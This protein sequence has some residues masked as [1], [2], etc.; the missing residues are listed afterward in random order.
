MN[1]TKRRSFVAAL[2][3]LVCAFV[4]V[5]SL[6]MMS[7]C[8]NESADTAQSAG[9]AWYYGT[10][11]PSD[12]LGENGDHYLNT[13]TL[14]SYVKESNV[15]RSAAPG[16]AGKW[17]YG[18]EEPGEFG[19][20]GDFYLKTDT[21][22]LY[23]KGAEGWEHVCTLKGNDGRDGVI[24]FSGQGHPDTSLDLAGKVKKQ[25]DFYIDTDTW[26]VYQLGTE[27]KWVEL[28]SIKGQTQRGSVWFTGKT[29]P[30]KAELEDVQEG[31]YYL[32]TFAAF[33][34]TAGYIIYR[35]DGAN[36]TEIANMSTKTTVETATEFH[37]FDLEDLKALR[38]SVN[39]DAVDFTGKT[40][41][42][43]ADINFPEVMAMA[44]E[45]G[46]EPIG[47]ADH[48]FK[49]TFDGRG[50][51][52]RNFSVTATAEMTAVGL[53]GVVEDATIENVTLVNATV[54]AEASAEVHA[55]ILVGEAKGQTTIEGVTVE[56]STVVLHESHITLKNGGVVG[57]VDGEGTLTMKDTESDAVLA[58]NSDLGYT[59]NEKWDAE[60]KLSEVVYEG[61]GDPDNPDSFTG[62]ITDTILYLGVNAAADENHT[63]YDSATY[64]GVNFVFKNIK[65]MGNTHIATAAGKLTVKDCYIDVQ[66]VT[67]TDPEWG[68][69]RLNGGKIEFT[70]NTVFGGGTG[71]VII[72]WGA[73][74]DGDVF[75]GNTFGSAERPYSNLYE[76]IIKGLDINSAAEGVSIRDNVFYVTGEDKAA[77]PSKTLKVITTHQMWSKTYNANI[78][79]DGNTVHDV[80]PAD[81]EGAVGWSL[82]SIEG[83]QDFA[84]QRIFMTDSN[85]IVK[86]GGTRDVGYAD[87]ALAG[88]SKKVTEP[89]YD[90]VGW[91]VKFDADKKIVSGVFL[92]DGATDGDPAFTAEDLL[93]YIAEDADRSKIGY[94]DPSAGL[95]ADQNGVY[96]VSSE[97]DLIALRTATAGGKNFKSNTIA[98][99]QDITLTDVWT[100]ITKFVGTFDGRGHKISGLTIRA[101]NTENVGLFG[102][103]AETSNMGT[104]ATVIENLIVENASVTVEAWSSWRYCRVGVVVGGFG[105]QSSTIHDVQVVNATVEITKGASNCTTYVGGVVG[106]MPGR[107]YNCRAEVKI[108]DR[109]G[110][111]GIGGIVGQSWGEINNCY[112][113]VDL[114][115]GNCG[116]IAGT[117][118]AKDSQLHNNVGELGSIV[119]CYATGKIEA[120]A[121]D[122]QIWSGGLIGDVH[123]PGYGSAMNLKDITNCYA[124]VT[125]N[126]GACNVLIG[127]SDFVFEE[128]F[129]TKNAWTAAAASQEV[130]DHAGTA[131]Q[132]T[133]VKDAEG[134]S[135][136]AGMTYEAYSSQLAE[137]LG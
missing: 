110:N 41:Y 42:L 122:G 5:F 121:A 84:H 104:G 8:G 33:S 73:W 107:I 88:C 10:A 112:A 98:L 82:I 77:N 31:D 25:G 71:A 15:W 127:H 23:Q 81:A 56:E 103:T 1:K 59:V 100:P 6:G 70:G 113:K 76:A 54:N 91:N 83:A 51:S 53:F 35:Y 87:L 102:L 45:T 37:I 2:F 43:D 7:A 60:G 120:T 89:P 36:W 72:G 137:L 132:F 46:W 9:G 49:G 20:A 62:T 124:D 78:Y 106:Y 93:A 96:L 105:W 68:F 47:T 58:N 85:K 24:W 27:D 111:A 38:K 4:L 80:T 16:E 48:P 52:I 14:T 39:E 86:N 101:A 134:C 34:D 123:D 114:S 133:V 119:N 128:G 13:E 28:G 22:D 75:S 30:D 44:E 79:I 97:A 63:V 109:T 50:M 65:F 126:E 95:M 55:G 19:T 66:A 90:V 18:T 61:T 12:T 94:Y 11:I 92:L 26:T 67:N 29:E 130:K 57:E 131:T 117:M 116:G 69:V 17:Y 99:T 32:L 74:V 21:S 118:V 64:A 135:F 3:A 40:V 108:V 125:V 129:A 136:R 115:G